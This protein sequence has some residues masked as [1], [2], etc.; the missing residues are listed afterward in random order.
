MQEIRGTT[1]VNFLIFCFLVLSQI[2]RTSFLFFF[3]LDKCWGGAIP[4]PLCTKWLALGTGSHPKALPCILPVPSAW[5]CGG[6]QCHISWPSQ[7]LR[8]ER[9]LMVSMP[10]AQK[11][12][13]GCSSAHRVP[14]GAALCGCQQKRS[15]DRTALQDKTNNLSCWGWCLQPW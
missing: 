4:A 6:K 2:P 12:R 1:G 7:D 14:R 11:G 15:E 3:F 10:A 8:C 9:Q 5:L 13:R